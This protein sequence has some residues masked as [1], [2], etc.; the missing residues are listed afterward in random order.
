M[1]IIKV[2]KA[3]YL[4]RRTNQLENKTYQAF[5]IHGKEF[6]FKK[7]KNVWIGNW[8]EAQKTEDDSYSIAS[9]PERVAGP[10]PTEKEMNSY[11]A[12]DFIVDELKRTKAEIESLKKIANKK[13]KQACL[14]LLQFTESLNS[15]EIR[16]LGD[17]I[18]RTL[19]DLKFKKKG[20]S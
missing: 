13:F 10:E 20:K 5:L 15:Y 2:T 6:L 1:K 9:R 17:I 4:G 3:L 16:R 12:K 7:V 19:V 14:P 8:Y 18:G 11:V